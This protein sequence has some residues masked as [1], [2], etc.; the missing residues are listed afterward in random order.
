MHLTNVRRSV[1]RMTYHSYRELARLSIW[2]SWFNAATIKLPQLVLLKSLLTTLLNSSRTPLRKIFTGKPRKSYLINR[3][4]PIPC[5]Y[6]VILKVN[7]IL[8]SSGNRC[9]AQ[10]TKWLVIESD[11]LSLFK[12]MEII[13]P[14]ITYLIMDWLWKV[15]KLRRLHENRS[16][17]Y[18]WIPHELNSAALSLA[19]YFYEI[20]IEK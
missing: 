17:S 10:F 19:T 2:S 11:P 6:D 15:L 9:P 7:I 20:K 12:I 13:S 3:P 8:T 16:Y 1:S 4:M 5:Q 18:W 14:F